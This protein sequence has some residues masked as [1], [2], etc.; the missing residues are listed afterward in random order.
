MQLK[1]VLLVVAC[2]Q[3]GL[4]SCAEAAE[5]RQQVQLAF[6]QTL[7]DPGLDA[8]C[9]VSVSPD[10]RFVYTSAYV[11]GTHMVFSRDDV[12]GQ[13]VRLRGE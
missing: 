2:C 1:T 13:P 7:S 9:S 12:A 5:L 3:F 10:G 4:L 6:V 8:V 11:S